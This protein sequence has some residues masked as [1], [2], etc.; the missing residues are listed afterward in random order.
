MWAPLHRQHVAPPLAGVDRNLHC[1]HQALV[2]LGPE[3]LDRR[4]RPRL[5]AL[6]APQFLD[7]PCRVVR[8]PATSDGEVEQN[9][10]HR[11]QQVGG[12]RGLGHSVA[13]LVQPGRVNRRNPSSWRHCSRARRES[14]GSSCGWT[15]RAAGIPRSPCSS[16]STRRESPEHG[17][18]RQPSRLPLISRTRLTRSVSSSGRRSRTITVIPVIPPLATNSLNMLQSND[19]HCVLPP[20]DEPHPSGILRRAPQGRQQPCRWRR[21][22]RA[23]AC[24]CGLPWARACPPAP[25]RR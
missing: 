23:C 10:Q 16:R 6:A 25:E 22:H 18:S 24:R 17:P 5:V 12:T 1:P 19:V 4:V 13:D 7:V 14:G 15:V 11:H 9:R 3:A 20:R 2:G 8:P 21:G